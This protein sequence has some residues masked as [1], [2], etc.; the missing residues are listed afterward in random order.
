VELAQEVDFSQREN[1]KTMTEKHEES[2]VEIEE[3]SHSNTSV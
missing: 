1:D 2:Q 3:L